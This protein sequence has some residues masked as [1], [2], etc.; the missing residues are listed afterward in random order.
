MERK[1]EKKAVISFTGTE[2]CCISTKLVWISW[3]A[4]KISC[5]KSS[6]A[7]VVLCKRSSVQLSCQNLSVPFTGTA[8]SYFQQVGNPPSVFDLF[9]FCHSD[10]IPVMVKC[11]FDFYLI[12]LFWQFRWQVSLVVHVVV[13]W[14]LTCTHT[15]SVCLSLSLSLTHTHNL[16]E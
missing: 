1:K 3:Q 8:V 16:V 5:I 14:L 6:A 13:F 11:F 4:G 12:V 7:D 10:K 9:L 2:L 15:V